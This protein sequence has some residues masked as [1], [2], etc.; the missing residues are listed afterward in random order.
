MGTGGV[1]GRRVLPRK[2]FW[3]S[4]PSMMSVMAVMGKG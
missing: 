2:I 3:S 4:T 1:R